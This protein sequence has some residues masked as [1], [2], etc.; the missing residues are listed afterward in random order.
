MYCEQ[1]SAHTL[2]PR[3]SIF[4][5]FRLKRKHAAIYAV[6]YA[7]AESGVHVMYTASFKFGFFLIKSQ[8]MGLVSVYR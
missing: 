3:L 8:H 7:L 4:P 1:S 5:F 2:L 6:V